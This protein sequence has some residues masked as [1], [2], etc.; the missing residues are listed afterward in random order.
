[1]KKSKP[2]SVKTAEPS[3][4]PSTAFLSDSRQTWIMGVLNATPDSFYAGSRATLPARAL[5]TVDQMVREGV[6]VLDV[7]GESTRPGATEISLDI[8]RER[9]LPVI[10]SVRERW[11]A[12][13][14]SIDTQKAA[15]AREALARG[16]SMVNDISALRADP[17][18]AEVVA[19]GEFP[20]VIMHMQ[21]T[22]Q[23]MQQEA[24]YADVVDDINR[25]FEERL[26][27][28]SRQRIREDRIILDPGIGFGKTTEHNM[29]I[30]RG[31][32]KF[33]VWRRPLMV[34]V[35]RKTFIG[36]WLG[37]QD[38]PLPPEDRLE[39]SVAAALWAVK[40][41]ARGLRVHDV[42][43]T[44]RALRLWEGLARA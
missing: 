1:M 18:M 20:V 35:S 28:A 12:L 19:D 37:T 36:R 11:P 38:L 31:L 40:E 15:V 26:R 10:E 14:L 42:G 27:F 30:L 8:E 34:G 23:T 33:L 7:G 2:L 3:L 22:P 6:D 39:G 41:G 16:V 24:H 17:G 43:P 5:T 4:P 9:V 32:S 13:P 29:D 25:F 44:R 21:G